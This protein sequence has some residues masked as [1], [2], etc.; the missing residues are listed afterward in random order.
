MDVQVSCGAWMVCLD[1]NFPTH[2][3]QKLDGFSILPGVCS[4]CSGRRR[5]KVS[6]SF[7]ALEIKVGLKVF[8]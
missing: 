2:M 7:I 4:G 6:L 3:E 1:L 8:S 5:V